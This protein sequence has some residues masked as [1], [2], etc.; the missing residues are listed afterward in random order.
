MRRA[1]ACAIDPAAFS[2]AAGIA[3]DPWQ[4]RLL[5]SAAPRILV[6]CSRQSGKSTTMATLALHEALYHDGALVVMIAPSQRQSSELFR[7]CLTLFRSIGRPV[8]ADS[9]TA[10]ALT[11]ENGSRIVA[12]PGAHEGSIRGYSGVRLLIVDEA[13]RVPD[14]LYFSI[15]PMLAVSGG[16][17]IAAST[18]FGTRGW[19]YEAWRGAEPWDRYEIPAASCPRIAPEF[20][21][22]ER[23]VMGEWWYSQEYDCQFLDAQSAAFRAAD[24][25]AALV[26]DLAI[27]AL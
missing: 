16:R 24:I 23:R 20:L 17:L 25:E 21:A 2:D 5:R 15:R 14:D 22:E 18:P 11:L 7:K 4:A 8:P 19:W 1:V 27:W 26:E 12:L 6:N 9:E 10:L 13:S 3:P